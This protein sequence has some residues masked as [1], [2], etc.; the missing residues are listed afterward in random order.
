MVEVLVCNESEPAPMLVSE[1]HS[2]SPLA[3]SL[4]NR[5]SS[6]IIRSPRLNPYNVDAPQV[7]REPSPAATP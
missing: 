7:K 4:N 1:D 3:S 6:A 5:P 2:G